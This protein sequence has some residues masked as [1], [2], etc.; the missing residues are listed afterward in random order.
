MLLTTPA[1]GIEYFT[2]TLNQEDL[3]SICSKIEPTTAHV[4]TT[5][6]TVSHGLPQRNILQHYFFIRFKKDPTNTRQE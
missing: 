2:Y 5:A 1:L 3:K 6:T 4:S